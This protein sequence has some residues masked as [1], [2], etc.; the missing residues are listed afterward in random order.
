MPHMLSRSGPR[1]QSRSDDLL[2]VGEV[3]LRFGAEACIQWWTIAG[4]SL[5]HEAD[6]VARG[7]MASMPLEA[8]LRDMA[9]AYV[10]CLGELAAIG[11]SVAEKAAMELTRRPAAHLEPYIGD[12]DVGPQPD[13]EIFEVDG[14]PFAMPAR[15]LDASQGWAMY[16]VSTAAANHSLGAARDILS[17]FDAG[18]GRTPLMIVGVDYRNSDF[19]VYPEFV[20]A[21]TVTVKGDPVGQL[22]TYYLAIVVTQE[23]TKEAARVAWGLEKTVSPKLAVRYA[24]DN[25]LFGVPNRTGKALSIRFPRFGDAL[26]FDLATFS[27]SRRGAGRERRTYWA[28]T[29]RGGSGEGKQIGG[30]VR[31]ELGRS[32]DGLCLCADGKSVCVCE[33]LGRFD[34]ADRLPAA[35]GWTE[36]QTAVFGP[37]RLLDFPR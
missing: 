29:T 32:G 28:M 13:G 4:R 20:V 21:L 18:G 27:I 31:L 2:R 15:V 12:E 6:R 35:N 14:K 16:F 11:P 1:R 17:A 24:A 10:N 7:A 3:A 9:G 36:R 34:I 22:F 23:F 37:P 19:G 8:L 5:A 25:V 30:S 33:M 26:S